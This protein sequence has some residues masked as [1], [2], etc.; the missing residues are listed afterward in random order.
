[1]AIKNK[2]ITIGGR[3]WL[4]REASTMKNAEDCIFHA[5]A[6]GSVGGRDIQQEV[7]ANYKPTSSIILAD[8]QSLNADGSERQPA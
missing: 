2:I 7:D 4:I 3:N 5:M 8:V 1:M 6:T